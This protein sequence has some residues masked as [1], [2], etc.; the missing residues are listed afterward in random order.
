MK[1]FKSI[2]SEVTQPKSSEEKAFKDMH[3]YDVKRIRRKPCRRNSN[4]EIAT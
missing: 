4:D 2:L 1:S 3:T